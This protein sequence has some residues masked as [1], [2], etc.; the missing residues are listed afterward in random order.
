MLHRSMPMNYLQ[1]GVGVPAEQQL[2]Q[3]AIMV[4]E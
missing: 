1:D 4:L 2:A 3:L